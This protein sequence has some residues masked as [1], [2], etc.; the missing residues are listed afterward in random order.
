MYLHIEILKELTQIIT[1]SKLLLEALRIAEKEF[2]IANN[3]YSKN[4]NIIITSLNQ[5]LR[6][7]K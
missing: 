2:G 3:L 4:L 6:R 7:I 5:I 1:H